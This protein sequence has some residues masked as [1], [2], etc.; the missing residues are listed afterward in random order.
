M[1]IKKG[2][3]MKEKSTPNAVRDVKATEVPGS[4]TQQVQIHAGNTTVLTVQLLGQIAKSLEKIAAA[5]EK[6]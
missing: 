3:K 1:S 6:K 5:L 4:P 2:V